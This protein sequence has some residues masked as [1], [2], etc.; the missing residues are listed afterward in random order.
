VAEEEFGILV[1]RA[2]IGVRV[3]DEPRVWQVLL[4]DERVTEAS[5]DEDH[6]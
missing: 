4:Q 2:V 1:L 6:A 5:D 3:E